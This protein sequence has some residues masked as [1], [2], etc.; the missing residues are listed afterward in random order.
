MSSTSN[1]RV[2]SRAR[3]RKVMDGQGGS[4]AEDDAYEEQDYPSEKWNGM[5]VS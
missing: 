4:G 1:R 3:K 5:V 2:S